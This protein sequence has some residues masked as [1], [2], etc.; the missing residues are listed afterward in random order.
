MTTY[1]RFC[2]F[3]E[4]KSLNILA[5]QGEKIVGPNIIKEAEKLVI[6]LVHAYGFLEN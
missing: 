6:Y 4:H 3:L 2:R 1:L 5:Y